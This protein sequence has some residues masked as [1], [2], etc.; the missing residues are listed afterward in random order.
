MLDEKAYGKTTASVI[1]SS[2]E[3]M[4][5]V[6]GGAYA[7]LK[8]L[9]DHW[10]YWGL[11]TLS[12]DEAICPI[13]MPGKD[14]ND[15]GYWK[16]INTHKWT[17]NGAA[18]EN[19]W[20]RS[21]SGATLCNQI[22]YQLEMHKEVAKP[23]VYDRFVA[24]L[25]ALRS[26]YY[27]TVFDLFGRI[28]YFPSYTKSDEP[29]DEPNAVWEKLVKDLEA[30]VENLPAATNPSKEM[31]Y[32]RATQ[33]MAYTL[34]ARLYLNAKSY[35]V[36]PQNVHIEGINSEVDFY[37][38][39]I[40]YCD[41]VIN[42]NAYH[43]EPNFFT[44]F[45]VHN[46]GSQENIFVIVES[47][48][49]TFDYQDY[50]GKM[51]NKLRITCL[52]LNYTMQT[53]W[54][55]IE[56]PW[57]G[58]CATKSFLNLYEYGVDRRG[59]CDSIRGS[60]TNFDDEPWGWFLG[61]VYAVNGKDTMEMSDKGEQTGV[62]NTG[63]P[64]YGPLK[65]VIRSTIADLDNA[66]HNDGARLLKYQVEKN[67]KINKFCENDFV[68]LR[69]ADVLYMKAEAMLRG[70][71]GDLAAFI[72]TPDFQL[73]RTRAGVTPYTTATL[74]LDEMLSERGRE[75]AWE[76]VRRRDLIRYGKFAQGT[77]DFK[78]PVDATRNWFPIPRKRIEVSGGKLTQN[79]GYSE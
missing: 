16:D 45:L 26:Y 66:T 79:P 35:G 38:K 20:V 7:E 68:L 36:T 6:V 27:Y 70:A 40:E 61:P 50:A 74:T 37:N 32:G 53:P 11:N 22:L 58:F 72:S 63:R 77:W 24:E 41:K 55:L 19:V 25:V 52:T 2:E 48:N 64:L 43:I 57:N 60:L 76:C 71:D 13:R 33:G 9:H 5:L 21:M 67:S 69:Y 15:D 62:D 46:E 28:R 1:L 30:N 3:N 44:N 29:Q 47:G 51:A 78:Q 10:G 4:A 34:L 8:W 75:F 54:G 42:S 18:F 65:A 73:I 12:A 23:E 39:C 17:Q 14:W 59:P 49:A 31:N 56:K